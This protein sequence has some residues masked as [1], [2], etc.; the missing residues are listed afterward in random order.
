[1][2]V[3]MYATPQTYDTY[4]H[5]F[6]LQND[7]LWDSRRALSRGVSEWSDNYEFRT[8]S[9]AG[10]WRWLKF[11]G[12]DFG[13]GQEFPC[14]GAWR[15]HFFV[16]CGIHIFLFIVIKKSFWKDGMVVP[17]FSKVYPKWWV[18]KVSPL[19]RY[20]EACQ[21]SSAAEAEDTPIFCG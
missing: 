4:D 19:V 20:C 1:M 2:H 21:M 13:L 10:I 18:A 15:G 12:R 8:W 7:D 17:D 6:G 16:F 9:W 14:F 3:C 11:L 5:C